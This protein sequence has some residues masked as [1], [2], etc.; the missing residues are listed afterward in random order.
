MYMLDISIININISI[1]RIVFIIS[2]VKYQWYSF[3][4]TKTS[5][6]CSS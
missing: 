1:I 2:T 3:L 4:A 6:Y 5:A